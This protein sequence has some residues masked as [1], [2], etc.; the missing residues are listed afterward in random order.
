MVL[1]TQ[2]DLWKNLSKRLLIQKSQLPNM[3]AN[4]RGW[5]LF[6]AAV[7]FGAAFIAVV[8][9]IHDPKVYPAALSAGLFFVVAERMT[10][11]L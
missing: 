4:L 11:Q 9:P 8:W 3:P 10:R 5:L 2:W 1:F 7:L 6:A